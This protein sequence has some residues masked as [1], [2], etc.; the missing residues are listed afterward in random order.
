MLCLWSY[1]FEVLHLNDEELKNLKNRCF[2]NSS[3]L[4]LILQPII[5][6]IYVNKEKEQKR[7]HNCENA[8]SLYE[9]Q[10]CW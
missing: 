8:F 6:F 5:L 10:V 3:G 2:W 7:T 4:W 9:D 1:G